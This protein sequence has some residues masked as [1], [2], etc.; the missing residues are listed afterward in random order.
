MTLLALKID[1]DTAIGTQKG[2]PAL[3]DL[4]TSL[5]IPATFYLSLGPDHTG[6]AIKRVF[7]K[8]FLKKVLATNVAGNYGLRTLLYGTLLPGPQIGHK[9]QGILQEVYKRGYNVGIHAFDHQAWQ[10][11]MQTMTL[12]E[13]DAEFAKAVKEFERIFGIPAETAAAPGWQAT[14]TTFMTYQKY[15]ILYSS[16]SRGKTPF[17]PQFGKRRYP[18]LQIPTTLPTLDE[19]VG[20]RGFDLQK[21]LEFYLSL[22]KHQDI[23][24]FNLHPELEGMRY[25]PWFE[26]FLIACQKANIQFTTLKELAKSES[27]YPLSEPILAPFPRRSGTLL[28]QQ[29]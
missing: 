12:E 24:V 21:A 15:G 17:Y 27:A 4:L 9:H 13:F 10:N 16:D 26:Q 6:R 1:V 19:L 14:E 29:S 22:I 7:Q 28:Q 20:T 23:V 5:K 18:T 3:L 2:V 11:G 25:L 8:G